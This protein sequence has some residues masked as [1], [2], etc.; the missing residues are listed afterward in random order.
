[1]ADRLGLQRWDG[2]VQ[3]YDGRTGYPFD[4][5]TTVGIIYILKLNH[6]VDNKIRYRSTGPYSDVTQQPLKGKIHKG[7]Q[8]L[9]EMEVWALQS[10]GAAFVTNEALTAK[11]DD[12]KARNKLHTNML[13]GTPVLLNYRNEG[14]LSVLK[15][16][17]AMGIDVN[18]N[19][20]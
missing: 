10:Y 12:V 1:M 3:L 14:V 15:I 7:G 6:L 17:F 13:S 18:Q 5:K 20:E 19:V 2:Q 4:K 11:C 8:R 9:G 16:L